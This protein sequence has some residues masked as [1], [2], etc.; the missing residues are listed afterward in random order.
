[1]SVVEELYQVSLGKA[2]PSSRL[3]AHGFA[4]RLALAAA[5]LR[6]VMASEG[7]STVARRKVE[8]AE[9]LLLVEL[10][11]LTIKDL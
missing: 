10:E 2:E 5:I 1:M 6:Q 3:E 11:A 4:L 8:L 7:G 9:D